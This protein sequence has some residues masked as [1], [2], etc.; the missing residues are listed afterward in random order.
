MSFA[1][2]MLARDPTMLTEKDLQSLVLDVARIAGW[3]H[4]HTFNSKHSASGFPDLVFVGHGRI[5]FAELKSET[6]KLSDKQ[7]LWIEDLLKNGAEVHVWR[8]RDWPSIVRTLTG[9]EAA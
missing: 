4:Y 9:R 8:P 7:K 6:G 5:V 2:Q 1:K 3:R